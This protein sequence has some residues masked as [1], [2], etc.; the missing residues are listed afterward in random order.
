MS[1]L[2]NFQTKYLSDAKYTFSKFQNKNIG[3][4][5]FKFHLK[6]GVEVSIVDAL[7]I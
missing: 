5:F 6:I 3:G 2:Q 4:C 7:Y 1:E